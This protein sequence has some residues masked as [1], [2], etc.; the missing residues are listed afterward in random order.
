MR[1]ARARD[2][3]APVIFCPSVRV[4]SAAEQKES[5]QQDGPEGRTQVL[6]SSTRWKGGCHTPVPCL[7]AWPSGGGGGEGG[8]RG[9][10][11]HGPGNAT[12]AQAR[13][14]SKYIP[15]CGLSS[16]Y[17]TPA[18]IISEKDT[19]ARSE[20]HPGYSK[21][22]MPPV[23]DTSANPQTVTPSQGPRPRWLCTRWPVV[24]QP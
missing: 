9:V 15:V 18:L 3:A 4:P 20:G 5:M 7:L 24:F 13:V 10:L 21:G 12:L 23:Q 8:T 1:V 2:A 11:T 16:I 14:T 22:Q 19:L 17:H 6:S